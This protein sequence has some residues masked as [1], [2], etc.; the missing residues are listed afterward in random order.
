VRKTFAE[1]CLRYVG[2][3]RGA[4]PGMVRM[5]IE[6]VPLARV[7]YKVRSYIEVGRGPSGH[8]IVGEIE[9]ALVEGERLRGAMKGSAGAD[10]VTVVGG[11]ASL[12]VR[13]TMETHD[14][15]LVFVHYLGRHDARDGLGTASAY[16]APMF[17]TADER[18]TWL[19]RILAVG[20]ATFADSHTVLYEWFEVR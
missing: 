8:R 11:V 10:W 14:G 9:S 4:T 18:Y 6:L 13:W 16:S 5:T 7:T 19:N 1:P 2:K 17:E 12:D 3:T 15:A 20:K